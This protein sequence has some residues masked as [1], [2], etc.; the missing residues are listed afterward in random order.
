MA[1]SYKPTSAIAANFS[2]NMCRWDGTGAPHYEVWFLTLN[3]RASQR[4]FWFRYVLES[5][6]ATVLDAQPRASLWAAVRMAR[7]FR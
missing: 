2:D 6:I 5:P 3:H 7:L 1:V 4:G